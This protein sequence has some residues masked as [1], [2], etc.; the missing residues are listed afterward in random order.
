[1]LCLGQKVCRNMHG[2]GVCICHNKYLAGSCHHVYAAHLGGNQPLCSCNEDVA[3]A[4]NLV[5]AG[6]ALRAVC[7]GSNGLGSAYLHNF[8]HTT[9]RGSR[10]HFRL[11]LSVCLYRCGHYELLNSRNL[12]GKGVHKHCGGICRSAAGDIYAGTL[13]GYYPLSHYRAVQLNLKALAL[14]HLMEPGDV[15]YGVLQRG[16]VCCIQAVHGLL[17]LFRSDI[18]LSGIAVKLR[19]I[20]LQS[21]VPVRA[22]IVYNLTH[23]LLCCH[24]HLFTGSEELFRTLSAVYNLFHH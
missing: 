15:V 10:Q 21:L 2:V 18:Q 12:C 17:D 5:H 20:L 4:C 13:Y 23:R 14:L 3:R 9:H 6:N 8:V 19:C 11:Y 24:R 1:M 7:E 16:D 22:H